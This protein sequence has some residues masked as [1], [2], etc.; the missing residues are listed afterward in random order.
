MS[1]IPTKSQF[2]SRETSI[3]LSLPYYTRCALVVLLFV[4]SIA[5][6]FFAGRSGIPHKVVSDKC[7]P[8]IDLPLHKHTFVYNQTFA[9]GGPA[10][11]EAWE[12]LFPSQGGFFRHPTISRGRANFAIFHQLHCLDKIREAYWTLY[13]GRVAAH[14]GAPAVVFDPDSLPFHSTPPH[15]GHCVDLIRNALVCRPDT[16]LEFKDKELGGV[17]GFGTEH[18]CV[19]WNQ[20][21]EWVSQW[22]NYGKD[23]AG[24]SKA[25]TSRKGSGGS[26]LPSKGSSGLPSTGS[27]GLP[28]KGS[29]GLPSTGSSGLPSKGSSGLPSKGS[30]GLPSK[31]SSGLPAKRSFGSASKF[32]WG[33]L[34]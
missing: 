12:S 15:V 18:V 32:L 14:D 11:D 27:S 30:S 23:S 26:G 31:G 33:K 9:E 10:A 1:H 28:S 21:V 2:S 3:N 34:G 24:T 25:S 22:E 5:I 29:S 16:T 7:Q 17:T 20:L 6:S 4:S 13:D 19:D 8:N